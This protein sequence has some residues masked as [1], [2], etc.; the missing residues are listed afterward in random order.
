[1]D[2]SRGGSSMDA[3]RDRAATDGVKGTG[4]RDTMKDGWKIGDWV[5]D[6][7]SVPRS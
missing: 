3:L 7:R 1:M 5:R 4:R 6:G 2:A